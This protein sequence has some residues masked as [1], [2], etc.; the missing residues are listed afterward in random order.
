M[1]HKKI[2][3]KNLI[4]TLALIITLINY[5]NAQQSSST[6]TTKT[7]NRAK[8]WSNE[9]VVEE[10][11]IDET[12]LTKKQIVQEIA[13]PK[14]LDILIDLNR[15]LTIKTWNENKI[16]IETSVQHME[17]NELTD[18]LWLDKIGIKMKLF[19]STV[20][21]KNKSN[22]FDNTTNTYTLGKILYSQAGEGVVNRNSGAV[23]VY[24]GNGEYL[25]AIQGNREI[26]LYIPAQ[27]NLEIDNKFATL[28]FENNI[29]DLVI[30]NANG[31]IEAADIERLVLRSKYGSFT[32]GSIADG[33]MEFNYGRINIKHLQNGSLK[34][35]Y[36]TAEIEKAGN[37]KLT[38]NSDEM[39]IEEATDLHGS[40][41]YGSLRIFNLKNKL[42]VI[43]INADIRLR[44]IDPNADLVKINNRN[45]ELRMP[46]R[47]LKNFSVEIK[48]NYNNLFAPFEDAIIKEKLS[49]KEIADMKEESVKL[50]TTSKSSSA[51]DVIVVDGGRLDVN[52]KIAA[53]PVYTYSYPGLS[54]TILNAISEKY[55]KLTATVG[56]LKGKHTKFVITCTSCTLDF[57]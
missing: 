10:N 32:A 36:T 31:N 1:K 41:S 11:K 28:K 25:G 27:S 34:S 39:D 43:G 18:E 44:N 20:K 57:K 54:S 48:G 16:K 3:M 21:V 51:S 14:A 45:A 47:S 7:I 4:T 46:V 9:T 26:T 17:K 22:S 24:H 13:L 12:K 52:R 42:E 15:N 6:S 8:E 33:D 49:E 55:T 38:S 29:K 50:L 2:N 19:G 23:S 5:L 35:S 37:V 30:D 56:D 40:K 53:S